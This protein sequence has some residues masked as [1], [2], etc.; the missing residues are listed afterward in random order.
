MQRQELGLLPN[1]LHPFRHTA[2]MH[3][4]RAPCR[5]LQLWAGAGEQLELG[6]GEGGPVT[7]HQAGIPQIAPLAAMHGY[8]LHTVHTQQCPSRLR[9]QPRPHGSGSRTQQWDTRES[10][11]ILLPSPP[12]RPQPG[13]PHPL[14]TP[15][16][17]RPCS[18]LSCW[19]SKQGL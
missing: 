12:T 17:P 8:R 4:I 1:Q 11:E 13:D 7:Q 10:P 18:L 16:L 3:L 19:T 14:G 2:H 6:T 9:E 15:H 5:P